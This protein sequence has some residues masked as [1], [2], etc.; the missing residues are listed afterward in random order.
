MKTETIE[1]MP[2]NKIAQ[3]FGVHIHEATTLQLAVFDCVEYQTR[4]SAKILGKDEAEYCAEVLAFIKNNEALFTKEKD[5]YFRRNIE[6]E[7]LNVL[8]SEREIA[9]FFKFA[10]FDVINAGGFFF[11]QDGLYI[12]RT[13]LGRRHFY[14]NFVSKRCDI[15]EHQIFEYYAPSMFEEVKK[16][17]IKAEKACKKSKTC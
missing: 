15:S 14:D 17:K 2:K 7:L 1:K 16:A 12:F 9:L 10:F 8:E 5:A 11:Y 3:Y 6:K 4:Q 13:E